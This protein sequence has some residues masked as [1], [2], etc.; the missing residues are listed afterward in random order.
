[1]LARRMVEQSSLSINDRT[2]LCHDGT[3][4]AYR[5]EG[6]GPA[7][8]LTNGLTTTT[9]FWKYVRPHWLRDHTVVTWDLPGHGNSGPAHSADSATVEAQPR[10]IAQVMRAAG[11]AH[12][13][14]VGWST[15]A[16]VV[17]EMY[18][19]SPE[20]C[21][22]VVMLLGG[23]GNTL[24]N[25]R[26]QVGGPVIDALATYLPK[27]AFGALFRTLS[28][29]VRRPSAG[30]IG[31]MLGLI[32]A[33]VSELDVQEIT[34]HIARVDPDMLQVFLRSCQTH[35]AQASLS[36][37]R[38]PL[39]IVAGDAD[40]F[41]PTDSVGLPLARAAQ[42]CELVRLPQGTH[43]ALLEEPR[44]IADSVSRFLARASEARAIRGL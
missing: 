2:L 39:L 38:V 35:S 40:P 16:Q 23:A 27:N 32:G 17:L 9:T 31:R 13:A 25:M 10:F 14:Q 41:A 8:V 3:R 15:G 6:S 28:H 18:R 12:A 24:A 21:E 19:Q 7:L 20:L 29:G 11:I 44:L 1:M 42:S 5:V 43:T 36:A 37:L 4:I 22:S 26:L 30:S 34:E 33:H